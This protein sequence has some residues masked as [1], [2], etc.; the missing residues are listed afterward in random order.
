MKK[1][2]NCHT[3]KFNSECL[4]LI[5]NRFSIVYTL[6]ILISIIFSLI[7]FGWKFDNKLI[8]F[9]LSCLGLIF[10]ILPLVFK[11]KIEKVHGYQDLAMEFKNL[12]RDFSKNNDSAL[13]LK[14][15]KTLTK[16]L[17]DYPIDSYTKYKI[18]T[19]NG[20]KK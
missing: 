16:K 15:L 4:E 18:R 2:N 1:E 8:N 20:T 3:C 11:E 7:L 14:K 19:K 9:V 13:N 17:A 6:S 12:E 5:S 10:T